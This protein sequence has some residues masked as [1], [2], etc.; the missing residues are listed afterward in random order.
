MLT[1][2]RCTFLSWVYR[3]IVVT[4]LES[5]ELRGTSM[6]EDEFA[7]T[8]RLIA[9]DLSNF[10]AWHNRSQLI[11]EV[12]DERAVDERTRE[13]RQAVA[14]AFTVDEKAAYL[15]HEINEIKNRPEDYVD[16][17]RT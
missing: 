1:K 11:L 5:P 12:L 10:F 8:I 2:D 9:G 15:R 13:D 17:K 4:K 6:T 7:Y 14:P 16:I 3:R